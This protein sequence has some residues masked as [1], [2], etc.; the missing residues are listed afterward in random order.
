MA[1]VLQLIAGIAFVALFAVSYQPIVM[2]DG[3]LLIE[4]A[5]SLALNEPGYLLLLALFL[6]FAYGTVFGMVGADY[7][8]P[9]LFWHDRLSSRLAAAT[10]TTLLL[11]LIGVLAW[12]SYPD[13]PPGMGPLRF[14]RVAGWPALAL[15]FAPALVPSVFPRVPR[16]VVEV[17][18]SRKR[19]GAAMGRSVST[20]RNWLG[21]L[22]GLLIWGS[23]IASGVL[24]IGGLLWLAPRGGGLIA[25]VFERIP[26]GPGRSPLMDEETLRLLQ[27]AL[28]LALVYAVLS[29]RPVYERIVSPAVAICAL[30]GLLVTVLAWITSISEGLVPQVLMMVLVLGGVYWFSI[31]NRDPYKLRFPAME[32]YYPKG[33][34]GLLGL[35]GHV[36]KVV[37]DL[38]RETPRSPSIGI[39]DE[40]ALGN[41]LEVLRDD[42]GRKPK[43]V[44]VA[45]SG[46]ALRSGLWVAIVLDRLEQCIPDFGRHVRIIT[47]ASGGM[48]GAGYYLLHRRQPNVRPTA[49]AEGDGSYVP[50]PWVL[51][52]PRDSLD[53]VARFIALRDPL[54]AFLPRVF[55]DDRGI[56]LEDAWKDL[57]I[58]FRDLAGEER[59]GRIPSMVLSPM[60]IEAGRR[61]LISN[62]DL[63]PLVGSVGSELAAD[64]AHGTVRPYSL[65]ALE[66]YRMFPEATGFRLATGVRMNASFPY[67]SPAVNLPT[68]PPRR[69][70]DAGAYDNYGIQVAASWI[71]KNAEWLRDNTSG[72]VLVQIRDALSAD[73][74]L[75]V[76]DPPTRLLDRFFRGFR[77]FTSAPEAA[78]SAR[79][80]AAMFRND[81]DVA[82]L[83]ER[84]RQAG[85][86]SDFF[87][88]VV[89]ENSAQVTFDPRDP[90]S[91]PGDASLSARPA[92]GVALNWY[93][94]R[95]ER[96]SLIAAI[97]TPPPGSRWVDA[98]ERLERVDELRRRLEEASGPAHTELLIQLQQ[99]ENYERLVGLSDWWTRP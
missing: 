20:E 13:H 69:V 3:A 81:E 50:S 84:F 98:R 43:L 79:T 78:E 28:V 90:S 85:K 24:I 11:T 96:D 93:I 48:V 9:A 74:R 62:L 7:G 68:D 57:R 41:W 30:L 49:S 31:V 4:V 6:A 97:P 73:S 2:E 65:S 33:A 45:V 12:F 54:L 34:Q 63:G 44:V 82:A 94:S 75:G 61:L 1:R 25:Q 35:R 51:D 10:A 70:F 86:G 67:V 5:H 17:L 39:A 89:F 59:A 53:P 32:S 21:Y 99:A 29:F 19:V 77:F 76:A 95:A 14:L 40:E 88:T 23:G 91:W 60:M 27:F 55:A 56:R 26:L 15:L 52:I 8:L 58:P 37:Q 64:G 80:A 16:T 72:V 18:V 42:S 22:L 36:A 83:S 47:G 92:S 87:T 71:H 38:G 66:F 46:G